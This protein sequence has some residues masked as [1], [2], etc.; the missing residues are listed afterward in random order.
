MLRVIDVFTNYAWVK[1]LKDKTVLNAFIEI[2]NQCNEKP[3]KIIFVELMQRWL[4]N[5]EIF[6]Y[7]TYN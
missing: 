5:N 2:L 3:D 6:I 1:S 4:D 7:S